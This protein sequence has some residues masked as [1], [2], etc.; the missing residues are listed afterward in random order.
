MDPHA[1]SR[2]SSRRSLAEGDRRGREARV[3]D[4]AAG[5]LASSAFRTAPSAL[6]LVRSAGRSQGFPD[7]EFPDRECSCHCLSVSLV[8]RG[9][10]TG[11]AKRGHGKRRGRTF[12]SRSRPI[13][14]PFGRKER[15]RRGGPEAGEGSSRFVSSGVLPAGKPPE[16]CR[17]QNRYR[18]E[19]RAFLRERE[20]LLGREAGLQVFQGR[21]GR[22]LGI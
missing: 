1:S 14:S 7:R 10:G 4:L 3:A 15:R 22:G 9:G 21:Q 6:D 16:K 11:H 8:N 12:R 20:D 17:C 18:R 5:P 13:E 19:F 2:L